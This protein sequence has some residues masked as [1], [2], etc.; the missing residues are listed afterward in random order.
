MTVLLDSDATGKFGM[1]QWLLNTISLL[2]SLSLCFQQGTGKKKKKTFSWKLK[3][4]ISLIRITGTHTI[5]WWFAS[6][7]SCIMV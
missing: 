7:P 6:R 5:S 4:Q 2:C 1:N 3:M